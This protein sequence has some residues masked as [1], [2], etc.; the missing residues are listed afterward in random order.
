MRVI[1]THHLSD[2]TR[3]LTCGLVVCKVQVHH[4]VQDTAMHRLE[5]VAHIRQGAGHNHGHGIVDVRGTHFLFYVNFYNSVF[6]HKS[7]TKKPHK[8]SENEWNGT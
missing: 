8:D 3:R 6:C 4:A 5:P 2:N 7:V 1:L